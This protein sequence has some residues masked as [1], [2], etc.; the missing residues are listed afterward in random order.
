MSFLF[1]RAYVSVCMRAC[2]CVCICV[3]VCVYACVCMR[4][5]VCVCL[6]ACVSVCVCLYACV[7]VCVWMHACVC[8]HVCA[9]VCVR[10]YWIGRSQRPFHWSTT[11]DKNCVALTRRCRDWDVSGTI[12][13]ASVVAFRRLNH[14]PVFPRVLRIWKGKYIPFHGR[15]LSN[16]HSVQIKRKPSIYHKK[17]NTQ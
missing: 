7:S 13:P 8:M 4:V 14:R 1:P 9:C 3:C 2:T 5:S 15:Y 12:L 16:Y 6:D 17:P 11:I 10:K